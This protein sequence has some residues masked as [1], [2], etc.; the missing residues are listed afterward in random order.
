MST[1]LAEL[2]NTPVQGP[3]GESFTANFAIH[4][5]EILVVPD[6]ETQGRERLLRVVLGL[7]LVKPG[8]VKLFGKDIATLNRDR[9]NKVRARCA[10]LPA[11]TQMV[12]NLDVYSNVALPMRYHHGA[13]EALIREKVMTVLE[14]FG[15]KLHANHRPVSLTADQ[16]RFVGLAR[17]VC[18]EPELFV[19]E[20]PFDGFND[21]QSERAAEIFRELLDKGTGLLVSLTQSRS[22]KLSELPNFRLEPLEATPTTW[23]RLD[24][25]HKK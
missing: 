13:D 6:Q 22:D 23:T 10:L 14:R 19:L 4:E 5:G 2:I 3:E 7:D 9:I 17:A 11:K 21:H 15:L 18:S 25:R 16:Q 24:A 20:D 12:S 1:P 8:Q